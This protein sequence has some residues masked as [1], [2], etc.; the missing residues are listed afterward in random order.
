[1]ALVV[2]NGDGSKNGKLQKLTIELKGKFREIDYR[3]GETILDA[4]LR[5]GL[6]PPF[7]CQ[8]GV[9]ASCKATLK[10]G[11]VV[12]LK[13]EALTPLEAD[14]RNILTCTAAATS[15]ETT[16]SFDE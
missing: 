8:E 14:Q 15:A 11:R 13:H 7:A 1:M 3:T 12:M 10:S 6:F 16:V 4:A 5:A 9:C 2:G